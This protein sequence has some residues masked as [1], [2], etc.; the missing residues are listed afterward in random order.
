VLAKAR[1]PR[2]PF[3]IRNHGQ[4]YVQMKSNNRGAA[5]I[6]RKCEMENDIFQ[7]P[8]K[9]R[10]QGEDANVRKAK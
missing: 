3:Y 10:I 2:E 6:G 1:L 9:V 7:T 8:R 4:S 5:R